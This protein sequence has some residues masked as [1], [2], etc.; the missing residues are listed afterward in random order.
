MRRSL[1]VVIAGLALTT[2]ALA[3]NPKFW[4]TAIT[5]GDANL[6]W[7]QAEYRSLWGK[8]VVTDRLENGYTRLTF[9]RRDIEVYFKRGIQGAVAIVTWDRRDRTLDRIGP[10]ATVA[11]LRAAY[12]EAKPV[13][14]GARTVAYRLGRLIFTAETKRIGDVMLAVPS[15]SPYVALNAPEC[16]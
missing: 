14:Q 8:P 2:T 4:I 6:H 5:I 15:V 11:A 3:V 9:P 13:R 1:L 16:G 12:S 7:S 10:C